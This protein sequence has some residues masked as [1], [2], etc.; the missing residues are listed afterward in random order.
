M[1][2]QGFIYQYH[3]RNWLNC[4][5]T[6]ISVE[7]QLVPTQYHQKKIIQSSHTNHRDYLVL[8]WS[9]VRPQ[10]ANWYLPVG[11]TFESSIF[12]CNIWFLP[13]YCKIK[14]WN[15]IRLLMMNKGFCNAYGL[16]LIIHIFFQQMFTLFIC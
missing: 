8:F 12:I 2:L 16:K 10:N 14:V 5:G 6:I 1:F 11:P 4:C 3:F 15:I 13:H 7:D 9:L